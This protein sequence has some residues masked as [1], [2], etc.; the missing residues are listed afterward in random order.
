MADDR[1]AAGTIP[2]LYVSAIAIAPRGAWPVGLRR[3]YPPDHENLKFYADI[4]GLDDGF[5][6]YL[7]LGPDP[8]AE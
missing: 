6:T 7:D 1:V 4:A 5:A 8:D 2:A 3:H